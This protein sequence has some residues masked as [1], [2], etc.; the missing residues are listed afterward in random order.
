MWVAKA[1]INILY[2]INNRLQLPLIRNVPVLVNIYKYLNSMYKSSLLRL[3]QKTSFDSCLFLP[4]ETKTYNF[5]MCISHFL[6]D[7]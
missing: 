2:N 4:V 5:G 6:L 1:T 3:V 7:I